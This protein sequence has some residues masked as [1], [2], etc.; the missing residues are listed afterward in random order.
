[1]SRAGGIYSDRRRNKV[2]VCAFCKQVFYATRSDAK[3]CSIAHRKALSRLDNG[4]FTTV[5][6]TREIP[7]KTR[8]NV[9][10]T[11]T[12][13]TIELLGRQFAKVTN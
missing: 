5:E 1:M 13:K 6:K 4:G 8:G 12:M 9:I 7:I 3:T 2:C 11:G 10:T